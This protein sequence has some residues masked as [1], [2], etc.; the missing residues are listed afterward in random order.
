MGGDGERKREREM[1]AQPR[2]NHLT[3]RAHTS[4]SQIAEALLRVH[5]DKSKKRGGGRE[6]EA[7]RR[8]ERSGGTLILIFLEERERGETETSINFH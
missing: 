6:A 1:K 4:F 8:V 3:R 7:W 5:D 2:I